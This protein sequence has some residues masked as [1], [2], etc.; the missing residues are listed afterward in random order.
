M[1]SVL[2]KVTVCNQSLKNSD[3]EC[4]VQYANI[5]IS[6]SVKAVNAN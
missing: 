4:A 5:C 3:R 6:V 2:R 1:D